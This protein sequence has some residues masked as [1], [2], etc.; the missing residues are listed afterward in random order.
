MAAR[1]EPASRSLAATN[2]LTL[3]ADAASTRAAETSVSLNRNAETRIVEPGV[4][5]RI[6]LTTWFEML[7]SSVPP[8]NVRLNSTSAT[9]VEVTTGSTAA[10]AGVLPSVGRSSPVAARATTTGTSPAIRRDIARRQERNRT[11]GPPL[12]QCHGAAPPPNSKRYVGDRR[13]LLSPSEHP[14][15]DKNHTAMRGSRRTT[16]KTCWRAR[17]RMATVAPWVQ[18][19]GAPTSPPSTTP[20]EQ[21]GSGVI[22]GCPLDGKGL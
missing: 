3:R 8:A 21:A 13:L 15:A 20:C 4:A 12:R 2:T 16:T 17:T 19:C 22:C 6:S 1:L 10:K 5:L 18:S 7:R 14:F 9:G 11:D